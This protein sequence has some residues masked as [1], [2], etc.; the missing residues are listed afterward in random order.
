M[1]KLI[2]ILFLFVSLRL[3]A[4]GYTVGYIAEGTKIDP[5]KKLMFAVGMV[6]SKN[7]TLAY[8]PVEDAYG[9]YQIRYIRIRDFNERTGKRYKLSDCYK[10]AVSDEIFLFY[11]TMDFETTCKNWNGSGPKVEKYWGKI[12]KHLKTN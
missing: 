1:K 5:F 12:K 10:K 2:T 7:D 9:I 4:P 8:N 3:F 6:E 11:A